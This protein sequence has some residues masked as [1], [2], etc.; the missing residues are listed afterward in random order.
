MGNKRLDNVEYVKTM[1]F[2]DLYRLDF[3]AR[4]AVSSATH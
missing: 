4:F 3:P 2:L 1:T